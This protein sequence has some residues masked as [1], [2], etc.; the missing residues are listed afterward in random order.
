MYTLFEI[1][2]I[3]TESQDNIN[4][5]NG[6]KEKTKV[7]HMSATVYCVIIDKATKTNFNIITKNT[8]LILEIIFLEN[9]QY[10]FNIGNK[11]KLDFS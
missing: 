3:I 10:R 9:T 4:S 7:P 5:L 8:R 2:I 6:G 1:M 11:C